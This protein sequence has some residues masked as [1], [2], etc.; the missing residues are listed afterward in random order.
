MM[1]A[2]LRSWCHGAREM[3]TTVKFPGRLALGEHGA[4]ADEL[5]G[6]ATSAIVLNI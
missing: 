4:R 2:S 3:E 6:Q 1:L 5:D